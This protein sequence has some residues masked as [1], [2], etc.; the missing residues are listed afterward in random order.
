MPEIIYQYNTSPHKVTKILSFVLFFGHGPLNPNYSDLNRH[1]DNQQLRDQYLRYVSDYLL[2]YNNRFS[3][4]EINIE[5]QVLIAKEFNLNFGRGGDVLESYYM[6]D[7]Y[8]VL[9]VYPSYLYVKLQKEEPDNLFFLFIK[10]LLKNLVVNLYIILELDL[11]FFLLV[12]FFQ[13][14]KTRRI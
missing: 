7:I 2:E 3:T 5:N 1:F 10:D 11:F 13:H 8:K 14:I 9:A 12:I 4:V 6:E